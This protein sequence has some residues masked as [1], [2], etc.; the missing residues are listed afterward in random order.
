MFNVGYLPH[1]SKCVK[2]GILDVVLC[3]GLQKYLLKL[4]HLHYCLLLGDNI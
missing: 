3:F 4:Y 2:Y 1:K